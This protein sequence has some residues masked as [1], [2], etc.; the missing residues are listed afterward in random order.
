M[1]RVPPELNEAQISAL[2][3]I[4]I[5][6]QD[7][8]SLPIY[9]LNGLAKTGMTSIA[10]TVIKNLHDSRRLVVSFFCSQENRLHMLPGLAIQLAYKFPRFR[11]NLVEVIGNN[12]SFIDKEPLNQMHE[13][14]LKPLWES[15]IS[16]P[17]IVID[18]LDQYDG[19]G[20]QIL[21]CLKTVMSDIQKANMRFLITSRPTPGIRKD[22]SL[23]PSSNL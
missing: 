15:D 8:K 7:F 12:E 6:V 21:S 3:E 13:L 18:G 16:N 10:K 1:S 14:I 2:N 5:W 19:E 17:V 9:F 20:E 23:F 11:S 22:Y 4:E